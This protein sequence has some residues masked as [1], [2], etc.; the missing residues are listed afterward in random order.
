MK[1]AVGTAE[2]SPINASGPR[3]RRNGKAPSPD[4]SSPAQIVAECL[5]KTMSRG[6]DIGIVIARD[7]R[8]GSGRPHASEPLQRRGEF[9]FQREID[10]IAGD[11]DVVG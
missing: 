8:H 5:H 9:R 3:R 4:V 11:G 1:G 10:E 2:E 6:A 7:R